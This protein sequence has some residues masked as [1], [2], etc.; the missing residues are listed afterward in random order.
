MV[1]ATVLFM[2]GWA[3]LPQQAGMRLPDGVKGVSFGQAQRYNGREGNVRHRSP[4]REPA[5]L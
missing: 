5:G 1:L 4:S 3:A 2:L